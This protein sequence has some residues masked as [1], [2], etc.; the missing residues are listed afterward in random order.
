M[1]ETMNTAYTQL[2]ARTDRDLAR[3][4]RKESERAAGLAASGR[5]IEAARASQRAR[6]LMTV[7]NLPAHET[8]QLERLLDVPA[9]ACA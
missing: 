4:I 8:A 5:Y 3:L 2:R 9:L 7:T 6:E 1:E